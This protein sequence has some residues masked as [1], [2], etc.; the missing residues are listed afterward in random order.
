MGIYTHILESKTKDINSVKSPE[1]LMKFMSNIKY[2]HTGKFLSIDEIL[3]NK[4]GDC[5][6]QSNLEYQV[7]KKLGL[8]CGRIFMVEYK[9]W[10]KGGG[11]T[12]TITWFIRNNKYYWFEHS[13]QN[14]RGIHGPYESINDLK[15]DI[16]NKWNF[17]KDYDKLYMSNVGNVKPGMTLDEYCNCCIPKNGAPKENTYF[18]REN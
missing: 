9:N 6:D 14:E 15:I 12:H 2:K 10:Y 7:F 11:S 18:K 3:E 5:H 16:F 8:K 1:E 17:E 4:Y 13:W